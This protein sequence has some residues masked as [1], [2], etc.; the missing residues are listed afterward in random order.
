[1]ANLVEFEAIRKQ[2]ILVKSLG[3]GGTGDTFLLKDETTEML[4]AFKKYVPKDSN[5]IDEYYERFVDEIKI[6]FSLSHPNVVR[7]YNY[8]LY[9]QK[10][11]GYLQMEFIEG[12]SIDEFAPDPFGG[13]TWS[14]IFIETIAA[15]EYLE[16]N[17]VLHRDIRPANI[18]IDKDENVK[19]IDFGF[20]K[21]LE[22]LSQDAKSVLLNWP[23]TQLPNETADESI[24]NHKTE[25]YF[26]GKLL[27][28]V[29]D[30]SIT[31]FKFEHII[32]K[33]IQLD[34][35]N[36][37]DSFEDISIEISQGVLGEIDFTE[38]QKEI[39]V[40]FANAL[41]WSILFFQENYF[42]IRDDNEVL[43]NLANLIRISSL[44]R[45]I[46][47]NAQLISCFVNNGYRY[48]NKMDIEVTVIVNFYRLMDS[49]NSYKRKI[50]LDNI[51]ARLSNIKVE[52]KEDD[53]P[54]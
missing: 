46:Q 38:E 23:V 5:Y 12:Q 32:E 43:G 39:Y 14:E 35:N 54:F 26:V 20:G 52:I 3:S 40:N 34:P 30:R 49:L 18:M 16:L 21:K 47:D 9:P 19:V 44:E 36:R 29:I 48:S 17:Q 28:N 37:Y 15:F 2:F 25:I 22:G 51:D 42:P 10:K 41:S 27:D 4:F 50:V 24:Y 45:I 7:V 1:M 53:L 31:D 33:M 11:S 8:Y 6:L 13:K